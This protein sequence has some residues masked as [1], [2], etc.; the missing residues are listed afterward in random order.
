MKNI[1]L[2]L[3]FV[4]SMNALF[5]QE[6]SRTVFGIVS[7]DFGILKDV[8]IKIQGKSDGVVSDN[9]GKYEI[10]ANEGDV[11]VFSHMGMLPTEITIEDV[12]RVLNVK[13]YQNVEELDNV[14]V[15]KELLRSQ[16]KLAIAYG[17]INNSRTPLFEVFTSSTCPP[18]KPG[19]E[20]L[21]GII[22]SKDSN[23]FNVLK[24]QQDFPGTGD[25]YATTE[26]VNRRGYYGINSV[27]RMEIDG[28]WDGNANSFSAALYNDAIAKKS[29]FTLKGDFEA[30]KDKNEIRVNMEISP[31]A[32]LFTGE[33][34][35]QYAIVEGKTTKNVKTNGESVF[36]QVVK[37]MLPDENG[38]LLEIVSSDLMQ[39]NK[40]FTH[41]ITYKANG[42][43]RLPTNGQSANRINHAS[44]NS[45]ED[46]DDLYVVGWIESGTEKVV[47]QSFRLPLKSATGPGGPTGIEDSFHAI[48]YD[49][50]NQSSNNKEVTGTYNLDKDS[51]Y[52]WDVPGA[53]ISLPSDWN[54]VSLCDNTLCYDA[55]VTSKEFVAKGDSEKDYIKLKSL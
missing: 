35:V 1:R 8:Y 22:D 15:A 11:L 47:L 27:P 40:K 33:F 16:D 17:T 34:K 31:L 50:V 23:E 44:E 26:T 4:L 29:F 54:F 6:G 45:I 10:I 24:F 20:N 37:K 3:T 9:Y 41:S 46:F 43:Y 12:T 39:A 14:T 36:D 42:N 18:C 48:V 5:S 51:T 55:P 25:P 32:D 19:N 13:L 49:V 2:A 28:G 52:V 7:D 30:D 21:H 38:T 53:T